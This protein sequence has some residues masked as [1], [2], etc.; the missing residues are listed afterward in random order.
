MA[1]SVI[2]NS[3]QPIFKT[4]RNGYLDCVYWGSIYFADKKNITNFIGLNPDEICFLRSLAK[5]LQAAIMTDTN[6][7]ND[8][9][10]TSEEIAICLASHAGSEKHLKVLKKLAKKC[11]ISNSNLILEPQKPL[12]TRDFKGRKTKL[13]NNCSGKHLM[14]LIVSKYLGF[15]LK[16]YT[17]PSHPVQKLIHKKQDE[18]SEFKSDKKEFL[19]FDGCSTPLWGLPFKNLAIAYYNFVSDK[20]NSILIESALK[21]PCIFGG[22]NRLDSEIIILGKGKLFSKVGANGFVLVYNLENDKQ[23]IV[24]MAQNNNEIRRLVT[25]DILNKLG[26]IETKTEKHEYNQKN[27]I[28]ADF[29]YCYSF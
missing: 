19:T 1:S 8:F 26:W 24:K 27:K 2:N 9:K 22:F 17:S 18:L 11:G 12:D 20:K 3:Y 25:L 14:M 4:T 29:Q 28:V 23:L 15:D 7:I 10:L 6:L 16:N 5:P 13:H 21:N